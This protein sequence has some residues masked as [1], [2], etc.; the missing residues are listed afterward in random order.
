MA[1]LVES[2]ESLLDKLGEHLAVTG[3]REFYS[4]RWNLSLEIGIG[5]RVCDHLEEGSFEIGVPEKVIRVSPH[6]HFFTFPGAHERL[7]STLDRIA[8]GRKTTPKTD[9]DRL[10]QPM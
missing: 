9:W 4:I 8:E 7:L 2:I 10:L 6:A 3:H 1:L 5:C